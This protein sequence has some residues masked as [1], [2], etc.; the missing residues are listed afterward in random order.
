MK[1][2]IAIIGCGDMGKKHAAAW[3]KRKD[4]QI[5]AVYD[6]DQ[7]KREVMAAE[8]GAD[9]PAARRLNRRDRY[10]TVIAVVVEA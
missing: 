4:S 9:S 8:T 7:Q 6:P 5:V 10:R 2:K 3:S 1:Y